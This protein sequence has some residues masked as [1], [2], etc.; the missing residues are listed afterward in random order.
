MFINHKEFDI[1]LSNTHGLIKMHIAAMAYY[2]N[3]LDSQSSGRGRGGPNYFKVGD[4][5]YKICTSLYANF[6]KKI[7]S[8]TFC[9]LIFYVI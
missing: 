9:A 8:D 2:I 4:L 7:S 5:F 3:T 6:R 1:I